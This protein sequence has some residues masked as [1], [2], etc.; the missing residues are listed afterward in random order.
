MPR[1]R[2]IPTRL[3]YVGTRLRRRDALRLAHLLDKRA[4][5]GDHRGFTYDPK[6]GRATLT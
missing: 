6:T 3:Y 1:V 4:G 2:R 5:Y